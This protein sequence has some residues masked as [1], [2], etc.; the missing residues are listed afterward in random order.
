MKDGKTLWDELC[1]TFEEGIREARSYIGMWESVE[2]YVDADR[3]ALIHDKLVRQAKDAIWWRDATMLYFQ[4][5]SKMEIPAD[6]TPTQHTLDE[7]RRFRLGITNYENP[8]IDRLPE[9][10]LE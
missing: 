5:Y 3:Y 9:Y 10:T 2:E 8:A 1:Y 6:C 4:Q 7:L